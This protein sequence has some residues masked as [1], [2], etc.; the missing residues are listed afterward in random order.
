MVTKTTLTHFIVLAILLAG[1]MHIT[2]A[3]IPDV[4]W[5]KTFG[6]NNSDIGN[7]V[8][9]TEDGGFFIIGFKDFIPGQLNTGDV[10]LIKTDSNGDTLWTKTYG[11]TSG[12]DEGYAIQKV[13]SGG[14]IISGLTTSFGAG[15]TDAYVIRIND[16]GDTLWTKTYGGESEEYT[17]KIEQTSDGGFILVGRTYSYGLGSTDVWLIRANENGDTLWTRTF[18]TA[19]VDFGNSVQETSDGG[20][21]VTGRLMSFSTGTPDLYLVRTDSNGDSLWTKSYNGPLTPFSLDEGKD[22]HQL[23]DDGFLVAGVSDGRLFLLRT[24][25]NGDTLW[26]KLYNASCTSMER[27]SDGGYIIS[28]NNLLIRLKEGADTIWTKTIGASSDLAFSVQQTSDG[29]FIVTGRTSNSGSPDVLLIRVDSD[30]TTDAEDYFYTQPCHFELL[31]NY[32]NPFNPAT[33][34]SFDLPSA[35]DVMLKVYDMLGREVATLVNGLRHAGSFTERFDASNLSSGVY[36]YRLTTPSYSATK[37][38][39]LVR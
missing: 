1:N 19:G 24:D 37:K 23:S 25:D 28:G 36:L 29:G 31:Q 35:G 14:Y 17:T 27:T 3:Q 5:T 11:D 33:N 18:G 15:S 8:V 7:S 16:N 12:R 20:F 26:T 38:L 4:L 9:Q 22:V 6:G 2:F 30:G 10:W 39:I 32:P 13:S 21:I 34:I